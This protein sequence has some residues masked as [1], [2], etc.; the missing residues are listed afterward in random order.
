MGEQQTLPQGEKGSFKGALVC[1]A[2]AALRSLMFAV[3]FALEA[4]QEEV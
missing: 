3:V 4:E 2:A 1:L